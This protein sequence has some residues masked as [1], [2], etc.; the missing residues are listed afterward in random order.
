MT[1]E[2]TSKAGQP[3]G[4]DEP[5]LKRTPLYINPQYLKDMEDDPVEQATGSGD[6]EQGENPSS[7]TPE[8]K[9][10]PE[11][12]KERYDLLKAHHDRK[13]AADKKRIEELERQLAVK[14]KVDY[15]MP[16]TP[17]ELEAWRKEF[18]D[19]YNIVRTVAAMETSRTHQE[20]EELRKTVE[21]ERLEVR[22]EKAEAALSKIHPDWQELRYDPNFHAWVE[23]QPVN[24]QEWFY[25]NTDDPELAAK[26]INLYKLEKGIL[27]AKPKAKEANPKEAT[28]D[29]RTGSSTP[30]SG[31]NQK[32]VWSL[33]EIGKLPQR[34]FERLEQEIDLALMEGRVR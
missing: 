30:N 34:E 8:L 16:S 7:P 10:T 25:K 24:I 4:Q 5:L 28:L 27:N 17:D 13:V 29:V 32:K 15:K 22:K 33:E 11:Q 19:V 31:A 18:P 21:K 3:N 14:N 26:G 20:V 2:I 12:K 6:P 23:E 9:E 1:T